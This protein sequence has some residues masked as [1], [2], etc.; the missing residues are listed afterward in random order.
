M[1]QMVSMGRP[2]KNNNVS[3]RKKKGFKSE[4]LYFAKLF[5]LCYYK[6]HLCC[7]TLP[8]GCLQMQLVVLSYYNSSTCWKLQKTTYF[9]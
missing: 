4:G 5:S 9:K 7:F 1:G 8:E 3:R 6:L 2:K